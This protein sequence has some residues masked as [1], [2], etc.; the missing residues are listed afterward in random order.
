M[1]NPNAPFGLRPVRHIDGSP[2]NGQTQRCYIS[3]LYAVALYIG[4]PVLFTPTLNEKDTT[5]KYPTVNVSAGTAGTI[6]R[7]VI[8]SFEEKA[9]DLTLQYNPA[10][11]ARWANVCVGHDVVYQVRDDGSGTPSKVFPGQNAI[12]AN[13]GGDAITG[14]SGYQLDATTPTTTQNY[15]LH[16]I[17]LAD[18]EDNELDD[19]AIWEVVLNTCENA[20]GRFLG[21]T[22]A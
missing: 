18:I 6:I 5:A 4:D 19:Y 7:G 8:T 3:A 9:S 15:T 16:I 21:I 17:G 14:L 2:W 1:S 22:A 20:T 12:C 11:T 10:S 13:A